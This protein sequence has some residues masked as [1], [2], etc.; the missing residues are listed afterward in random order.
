MIWIG[1]LNYEG[2]P[3]DTN[4]R[5]NR[6]LSYTDGEVVAD[7]HTK[8]RNVSALYRRIDAPIQ[9]RH[10]AHLGVVVGDHLTIGVRQH[11]VKPGVGVG[12]LAFVVQTTDPDHDPDPVRKGLCE[13]VDEVAD[14]RS[15][16]AFRHRL[17]SF[18]WAERHILHA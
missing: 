1:R 15:E 13:G 11:P 17:S 10:V 7:Y 3:T 4:T 9:R 5:L 18:W 2:E 6:V 8:M 14:C 16:L 12:G